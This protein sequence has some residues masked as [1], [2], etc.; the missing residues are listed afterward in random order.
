MCAAVMKATLAVLMLACA[1]GF[2]NPAR[3]DAQADGSVVTGSGDDG[4][5]RTVDG[6]LPTCQTGSMTFAFTGAPVTVNLPGCVTIAVDV[7][8]AAGGIASIGSSTVGMGA[9]VQGSLSINAS[10]T[11]T[12]YVGGEGG[13][14]S[15]DV[16]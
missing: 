16:A 9:R 11:I 14:A 10:S 3:V 1:C 7:R 4:G 2:P 5:G 8:G 6:P 13:S 12:M 15:G